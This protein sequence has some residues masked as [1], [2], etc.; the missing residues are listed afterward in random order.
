MSESLR[1]ADRHTHLRIVAVALI[2]A[3]GVVRIY[4]RDSNPGT[5]TADVKVDRRVI[6]AGQPA[7]YTDRAGSNLR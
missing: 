4:A 5:V 7:A 6:K 1:S 2:A 3:L